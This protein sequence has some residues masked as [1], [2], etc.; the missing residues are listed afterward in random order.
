MCT[1]CGSKSRRSF[2]RSYASLLF[3]LTAGRNYQNNIMANVSP[4]RKQSLQQYA[5]A[6]FCIS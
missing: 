6:L 5:S 4:F 2:Q 3:T 1:N